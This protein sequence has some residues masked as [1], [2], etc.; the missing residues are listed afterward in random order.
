MPN[1]PA[2]VWPWIASKRS[3]WA[4]IFGVYRTV[5]E[6]C[7]DYR[8]DLLILD[9]RTDFNLELLRCLAWHNLERPP[10]QPRRTRTEPQNSRLLSQVQILHHQCNMYSMVVRL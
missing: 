1:A 8:Y 6:E 5:H 10:F 4:F 7:L 9:D 3:Q 2:I